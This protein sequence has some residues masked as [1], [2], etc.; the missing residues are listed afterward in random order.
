MSLA[1]R[2]HTFTV[3]S[4]WV[5]PRSTSHQGFACRPVWASDPLSH[6]PSVLPSTAREA[7]PPHP[8]EDMRASLLSARLEL[9]AVTVRVARA[10]GVDPLAFVAR[11]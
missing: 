2:F 5:W 10:D 3:P 6:T 4:G 8:V 11:A 9:G 1:D 7:T